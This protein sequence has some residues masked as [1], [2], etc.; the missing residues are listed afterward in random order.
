MVKKKEVLDSLFFNQRVT[1][2]ESVLPFE[3][4]LNS[5]QVVCVCCGS[6]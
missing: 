2:I 6:F 5:R 3:V 4:T 1:E